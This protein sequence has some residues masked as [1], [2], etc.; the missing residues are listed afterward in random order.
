[1]RHISCLILIVSLVTSTALAQASGQPVQQRGA[2]KRELLWKKLKAT[3]MQEDQELDAVMGVAI[4]DL[5]D[6]RRLSHNA[7]EIFPVASLIK[8]PVLAELY[9]QAEQSARGVPGKAKLTDTYTMNANDVVA[10]SDIMAG[11]TPNVT[12]VTNRD[13]ATFVVAVSDNAA[14]N[15]LI[16]RLGMEN[17]NA[18][19]EGLGLKET[20]LRRKMMD[21]K[22]AG[23]GREN[24]STPHEML[25]LL[26]A[27]YRN[28]LFSKALTDDF[29]KLLSTHK[30]SY[31]PRLLPDGVVVA[32]KHGVLEAVRTDSGLVFLKNRPFII[33][34][35]TTYARDER[36][37][38][39]TISRV[40]AAAYSYFDRLDRASPYGR[41]ISPR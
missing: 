26:E 27:I 11:L 14:T 8:V 41:V 21:L 23:E 33:S 18:L 31:I 7:D 6:G 30:E 1:M 28:K 32:N 5:T 20:R 37:A 12:R 38:E 24:T 13:L 3:V 10:G 36:A 19:L 4:L 2:Q 39:L 29:F 16:E 25:T 34:V 35:M 22:A 40:A 9:R 15:V 17:V